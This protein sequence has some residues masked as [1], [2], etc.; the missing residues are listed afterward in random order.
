M[1]EYNT[2]IRGEVQL[3]R[4]PAEIQRAHD[5]LVSIILGEIPNPF[6]ASIDRLEPALDKLRKDRPDICALMAM[7][8]NAEVLCWLLGHDHNT[9]FA[10]NLAKIEAWMKEQ[11]IEESQAKAE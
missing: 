11:G 7:A 8:A 9:T 4:T 2:T 10:D 6:V 1:S 3:A 5:I